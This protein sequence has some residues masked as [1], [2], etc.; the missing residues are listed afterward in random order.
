MSAVDDIFRSYRAP[1]AV[2]RAHLA[3]GRSEP[4]A[5]TFLLAALGV[6]FV[7]QWP[8]LSR[9][10]YLDPDLP[11][12]GL[13]VGT[14]LALLAMIPVFYLLA[15]GAHGLA[16]L[17]GGRGSGYGARLALF[18]A[19]LAASPLMLLQ[20]LVSGFLGEGLQLSLVNLLIFGAFGLIWGAGIRVAEFDLP[21]GERG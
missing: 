6:I 10:A 3:R 1:R 5:L 8:R 14:G 2:V 4:R 16:R 19:L 12:T 11:M 15:L 21:R 18:W 20:G 13:M 7:A 17:A 9:L